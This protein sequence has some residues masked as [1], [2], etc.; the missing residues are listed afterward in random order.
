MVATGGAAGMGAN[1]LGQLLYMPVLWITAPWYRRLRMLTL[2]DFFETRYQSRGI[3]VTYAL[4]SA[5]F[6]MIA[7]GMGFAAMGKTLTAIMPK[8]EAAL[9]MSERAEYN[10]AVELKAL[11]KRDFRA[12]SAAE[13]TRM[14]RLRAEKPRM[15][16]PYI[17]RWVILLAIA[18][19][20]AIYV[21]VGGLEAAFRID[22]IQGI[23]II[24]LTLLLIPFAMLRINAV[25]GT[26]GFLGP[27]QVLHQQFPEWFFELWGSPKL[28]EF[29]V[30]WILAFGVA[31]VINT[32]VQ[33]NQLTAIGSAKDEQTARLGSTNGL[34]I[35]RYCWVIWGLVGLLALALFGSTITDPDLL[36]GTATRELLGGA[37]IGLVGLMIAGLLAAFM[38]TASALALTTGALL[39]NSIY[40]P[41]APEKSE[42]HYVRVGRA[43]SLLYIVGGLLIA[44]KFDSVFDIFKYLVLFNCIVAA[45]FWLGMVWRRANRAAAWASIGTMLLFTVLLPVIIPLFPGMRANP[46]LLKETSPLPVTR[47]YEARVADVVEREAAI[48]KWEKELADGKEVGVRPEPLAL[49]QRFEKTFTMKK[50]SVFWWQDFTT[51]G[52]VKQGKGLLKVELLALDLLGWELSKNSYSTNETISILFRI[53]VPFAVLLVVGLCTRPHAKEHLDRFYARLRTPV[54]PDPELDAHEIELTATDPDRYHRGRLFPGTNWEFRRWDR[55]DWRGIAITSGG[56]IGVIVLLFIITRLGM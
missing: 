37:N 32:A 9:T 45:A 3:A 41:L 51:K 19:C 2:A 33:A 23:L 46:R 7:A 1:L 30:W 36:W 48:L 15:V 18:L 34:F 52:D 8:P 54:Q 28:L 24:I 21:A 50:K 47:T 17:N 55:Q 38:S 39:T 11:E 42:T 22:L 35:K 31:N 6:F 27:F 53:I 40:K 49:G 56:A 14:E 44:W 12:L 16:F 13:Q 10:R 4:V 26:T 43:L 20:V 29:S 5:T 25:F